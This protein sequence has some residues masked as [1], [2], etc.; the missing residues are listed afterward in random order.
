MHTGQAR[1]VPDHMKAT[2]AYLR[3]LEVIEGKV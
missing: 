2:E 3:T 1:M